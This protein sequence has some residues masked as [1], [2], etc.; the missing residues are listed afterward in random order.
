MDC[1]Q[2]STHENKH[3]DKIISFAKNKEVISEKKD[4]KNIKKID[5]SNKVKEEEIIEKKLKENKS[6]SFS[7]ENIN[8]INQ[9]EIEIK[10]KENILNT[11]KEKENEN[12][13]LIKSKDLI[14][15]D[16]RSFIKPLEVKENNS[17]IIPN[18]EETKIEEKLP[19]SKEKEYDN[20]I[21]KSEEKE[22]IDEDIQNSKEKKLKENKNISFSNNEISNEKKDI[23]SSSLEMNI[24][25]N[26]ELLLNYI[27]FGRFIYLREEPLKNY[28]YF[29]IDFNIC[30]YIFIVPEHLILSFSQFYSKILKNSL[31]LFA[32]DVH[33]AK[34]L[35]N[36]IQ[37][38][39]EE[40]I[41]DNWILISP[42]TELKKNIQTFNDNKNI[43]SI[44]GYCLIFYH[45]H[46]IN[47]LYQFSKYHEMVYLAGELLEILFKL[48]N[49]YYFKKKQ[50]YGEIINNNDIFEI[51]YDTKF[52]I[53]FNDDNSKNII[54]ET[55]YTELYEFKKK[56]FDSYFSFIKSYTLINKCFDDGEY[57]FLFNIIEK[58]ANELKNSKDELEKKLSASLLFKNLHILYLYFSN[59]PYLY[60]A[61]SDEEINE[62]LSKFEPNMNSHELRTILNKG[63]NS[64]INIVDDL[65]IKVNKG[66]SILKEKEKLKIIQ[67]NF[68][69][70]FS[71]AHL[72]TWEINIKELREYYQIK[73]FLRD[74]DYCLGITLIEMIDIFCAEYPL[75]L[76]IKKPFLLKEKRNYIY[77]DYEI[78]S[79]NIDDIE[80]EEEK[81][82]N[83]AIKYNDTIVFGDK[84]FHD[85][86]NKINLPF[87]NIYY[88]NEEQFFNF[89]QVPKKIS[90]KYKVCKY[91][92]IMDEQYGSKYFETINYIS[93]IYA[94]KYIVIIYFHNTNIK[95]NKKILQMSTTH[96]ILTYSPKDLL[97]FYFDNYNRL[98]DFNIKYIDR[99]D[100]LEEKAFDNNF[101]F[102]FP[103]LNETKVIKEQDN[104]WDMIRNANINIFNSLRVNKI[105]GTMDMSKFNRDMYKVYKENNCQELFIKY[106]GNYLLSEYLI[107]QTTNVI[108]DVKLFLH[109]YTLEEK[110]GKSFYSLINND[111]RSG[112]SDK[113]RRYF[114]MISLI[115]RLIRYN[116][117]KSFCG[118]I[119]RATYFKKELIDEIKPG[120]KMLNAS[121]W[122]SSKKLSVAKKFLF[123]LKKNVLLHVKVTNGN[124]IDIH[125]EN[126]SQYPNEEE[127]LILP[128]C[129]FEVKSFTKIMEKGLEY[130]NLELIYCDDD[131]NSKKLEIVKLN[132]ITDL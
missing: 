28:G 122:S 51:K 21:I 77:R 63:I 83:K 24:I 26:D 4:V 94:F 30:N 32:K 10:N 93:V 101:E 108:I 60:G 44:I 33:Q 78:R 112:I 125:L 106:Y 126:I 66:L 114:P 89:F 121:L 31:A 87:G 61:L 8:K 18:K 72:L 132:E 73:N 118:D 22:K 53:D 90:N 113:I 128:F 2:S 86:I 117:L 124:N 88:L 23:Q 59:Y 115:H 6:I 98:K 82:Y 105:Y 17:I 84:H 37:N 39:E 47:F 20:K 80:T 85:L 29:K 129:S 57:F 58:L 100:A 95:V 91:I 92:I 97:N 14:K 48:N 76:E 103:K 45:K 109:A 62:T 75:K 50:N 38:E 55:K 11:K 15:N 19:S 131:N 43:F 102:E 56:E 41:K 123:K 69:E 119:Y 16:N 120:K 70:I 111:L 96:M 64:L 130:Y 68:I 12:I 13:S 99:N 35:L 79:K 71:S 34:E 49:V 36:D 67:R 7:S 42:C 54:L 107:E 81:I 46:D 52:L 9:E 25:N 104:G 40:E 27:R 116:Y 5:I 65:A 127:I 74:I 110:D 3:E 1:S